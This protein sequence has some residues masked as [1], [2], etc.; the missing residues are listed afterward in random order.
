M[1]GLSNIKPSRGQAA[2]FVLLFLGVL[3]LSLFFVFKAGKVTSQRMML[4]NAADASAYTVSTVEAR[5]LNFMAYTNRAMI[6]NEVAIGQMVG[7]ASWVYHWGSF[8]PYL[9]AY[10]LYFLDPLVSA[11]SL[12]T[13]TVP[14]QNAFKGIVKALFYTTANFAIKFIE[15][16]ADYGTRYLS[17][18]NSIFSAVQTGFHYS[19]ILYALSAMLPDPFSGES[20]INQNAPGATIS[21]FG[22]LSMIAHTL[23]YASYPGAPS[24][25][26][27][28]PN[29]PTEAWFSRTYSRTSKKDNDMGGYQ[30]FA[31]LTNASKD[32]FS[33]RRGWE[34]PMPL[35]PEGAIDFTGPDRFELDM[36]IAT[37][38]FE[39]ELVF[40]L[41]LAKQGGSELRYRS[42]AS[43]NPQSKK[44]PAGY[45]PGKASDPAVKNNPNKKVVNGTTCVP[46]SPGPGVTPDP[47]P[48]TKYS[49]SAGDGTGLFVYFKL[50]VAAGADVLGGTIS[51]SLS[52]KLKDGNAEG[53]LA[54]DLGVLG[55][56]DLFDISLP[57]PTSA[58]FSSG[59]A[60][61][62]K[63]ANKMLTNHLA[64]VN[65]KAYG[66]APSNRSAWVLGVPFIPS[67]GP[68][69]I[70]PTVPV[71]SL[72]MPTPKHTV[73]STYGGLPPFYTDTQSDHLNL[74]FLAPYYMSGVIRDS[75]NAYTDKDI[76]NLGILDLSGNRMTLDAG[77]ADEEVAAIA[78]SSV[79]FKRPNDLSYFARV[80]GQE[81]YGSA[82]N[83]YWQARLVET[84]NGDRLISLAVQQK[85][86]MDGTV[87]G[88]QNINLS[89]LN[90]FNWLP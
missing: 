51:A 40:E 81:E 5:D 85:Q 62:A 55:E 28:I 44:C 52:I 15:K 11:V 35:I 47:E 56:I 10:R 18:V 20:V 19:T 65:T 9:N 12:G 54:L 70:E 78:K 63:N 90:P 82:F 24:L 6:A 80:D 68:V 4:Q 43:D 39:F 87:A 50:H 84:T 22:V 33:R 34:L 74:G 49:W 36:A 38:W 48:G 64:M 31:A 53:K 3:I 69:F 14:F 86:I 41:T 8:D 79:Y 17:T 25:N 13:A 59:S 42:T 46:A 66:E 57:F 26:I 77:D 58:P 88:L 73:N 32:D 61:A 16:I 1:K 27:P 83:P 67:P 76:W 89:N 71:T 75:D 7:L 2:V 23:T 21:D 37:V 45:E 72:T 30:R 60:Q 29:A